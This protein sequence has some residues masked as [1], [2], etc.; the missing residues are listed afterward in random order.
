[1]TFTE[2]WYTGAQ[3][4]FLGQLA[5][6][7]KPLRGTVLEFGCWEGK[8]TCALANA[9]MP[10]EVMAVDTWQGNLD[11][12]SG[13]ESVTLARQRD[14]FATFQSNVAALTQ[15]NVR[16][17]V[18]DC[19]EFMTTFDEP[20]KLCHIDACHDFQS[21]KR[22]IDAVLPLVV[23]GGILCGDDIIYA[24]KLRDDLDG[25]V[26]RAVSECLVGYKTRGNLWYWVR[27]VVD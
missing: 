17:V 24:H 23:K 19:H 5:R 20:I 16:P 14:V 9:V 8:S 4:L 11:E 26:E 21:V 12:S 3:A 18:S 22:S 27:P 6:I 2:S 25:G 13:H 10:D 1:M 7:T 15:G